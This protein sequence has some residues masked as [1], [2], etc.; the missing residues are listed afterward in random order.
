[1]S[2]HE[3][4]IYFLPNLMTAGNLFCGFMAVLTI[5]EGMTLAP[6]DVALANQQYQTA[7]W[8][9][10]GACLFDLLDG[11]LA[12]LGGKESPFGQEFDSIAD[13]VS[14]G[15]AP[16]LLVFNVVL[17]DMP[18]QAGWMIAFL[19]LLCGAM[20]LARFNCMA[21]SVAAA[22]ARE[23]KPAEVEEKAEEKGDDKS[24]DFVGLPVPMAA[25]TVA[26]L[27]I[28]MM[29]VSEG[30]MQLGNWRYAL[31]VL[32]VLLSLMM[33]SRLRYP[34][35]KNIS[36]TSRSSL[37]LIVV[38]T[39]V[40]VLMVKFY[41]VAPAV[42]CVFYVLYGV[43]RPWLSNRWRRGIEEPLEND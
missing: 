16:A 36:L 18:S 31:P 33:M 5:F 8:L 34:S 9:I 11:R 28:F 38:V 2:P 30:E 20:R 27:T 22:G 4:K 23:A 41:Y 25:A 13:V 15:V 21:F 3:P 24:K 6:G 37:M 39:M 1:M 40:L 7:I 10:F 42:A 14:F 17:I 29:W 35:F 26:S 19:F 43:V 32:M 12:R